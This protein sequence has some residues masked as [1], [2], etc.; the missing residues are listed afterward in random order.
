MGTVCLRTKLSLQECCR[1]VDSRVG[2]A[3]LR[4]RFWWVGMGL[5]YECDKPLCGTVDHGG[6]D[7]RETGPEGVGRTLPRVRGRWEAAGRHTILRIR[8]YLRVHERALQSIGFAFLGAFMIF[9]VGAI[10]RDPMD[11]ATAGWLLLGLSTGFYLLGLGIH[12]LQMR[13]RGRELVRKFAVLLEA[14]PVEP[15]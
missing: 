9:P 11:S 1:R 14:E 10:W 6:F 8:P 15:G 12:A 4:W 13:S 2:E 3:R 7:V 5:D